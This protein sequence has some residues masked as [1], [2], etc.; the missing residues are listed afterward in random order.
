M[1]SGSKQTGFELLSFRA[2]R[3][4]AKELSDCTV[5]VSIS[6]NDAVMGAQTKGMRDKNGT[7]DGV[8]ANKAVLR[9]PF[10]SSASIF[11]Y[12]VTK[13]FERNEQSESV[14]YVHTMFA[15]DRFRTRGKFL[16]KE[17]LLPLRP[18]GQRDTFRW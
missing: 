8:A 9:V 6:P 5:T 16:N 15:H 17:Q 18:Q 3:K 10:S 1:T 4:E 14:Q 12:L 7:S 11:H 2:K 13:Q